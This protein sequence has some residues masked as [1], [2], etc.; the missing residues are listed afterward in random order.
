[1][2]L[3][4]SILLSGIKPKNQLERALLAWLKGR[5]PLQ[6]YQEVLMSSRVSLII[7]GGEQLT[8]GGPL[9]FIELD[10]LQGNPVFSVFTHPDRARPV[11]KH[12]PDSSHMVEMDF[13]ELLK[14]VPQGYGLQLN[15]GT[16]FSTEL[17]PQGVEELRMQT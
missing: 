16:I 13:R 10:G 7:R 17:L 2:G 11:Q 9:R 12:L 6:A 4:Y 14:M 15:T 3:F 5:L 8:Q 1:M